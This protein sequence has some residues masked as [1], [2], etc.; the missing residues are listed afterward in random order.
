MLL[1]IGV[2]SLLVVLFA[3][4]AAAP[5]LPEVGPAE[6]DLVDG[7]VQPVVS[8]PADRARAA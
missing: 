2:L 7:Q 5:L 3:L 1:A 6:M 8:F 4:M